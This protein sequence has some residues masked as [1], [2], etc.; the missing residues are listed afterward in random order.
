MASVIDVIVQTANRYAIDPF[1]ALATAIKESNLNPTAIGDNG[2]SFGLYQVHQGGE[3]GNL[4]QQQAFDPATNADVALS[5]FQ[6]TY[7]GNSSLSG[8]NLAAAAQRPANSQAYASAVNDIYNQLRNIAGRNPNYNYAQ[9]IDE[10]GRTTGNAQLVGAFGDSGA[11]GILP[12][13]DS[14]GSTDWWKN[15]FGGLFGQGLGSIV[16]PHIQQFFLRLFMPS[17]YIRIMSGIGAIIFLILGIVLIVK[18][19]RK[20][21][22]ES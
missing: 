15:L 18:D 2:T 3:L 11:G 13:P 14:A 1:L 17:T 21:S 5:V 19:Y 6:Q 7:Q 10:Y 16:D 9:V 20:N 22:N 12:G 4:S 8:G